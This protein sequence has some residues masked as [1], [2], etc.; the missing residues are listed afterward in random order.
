MKLVTYGE[1]LQYRYA[2]QQGLPILPDSYIAQKNN[3][4]GTSEQ[5]IH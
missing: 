4:S 3:Y 2:N 5:G 1:A